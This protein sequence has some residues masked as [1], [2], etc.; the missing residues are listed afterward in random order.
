MG[1]L[2]IGATASSSGK[3][4]ITI[5]IL[6]KLMQLGFT[7][8]GAKVG[9]DFIDPMFHKFITGKDSI[10]LDAFISGESHVN[11][12]LVENSSGIDITIIEG[13]LGLYDG[14]SIDES[15][16]YDYRLRRSTRFLPF[17]STA[18]IAS[19]TKTPVILV[20]DTKS[21]VGSSVASVFGF[22]NI[23]KTLKIKG[24]ILNNVAN[25][26]HLRS[27][28]QAFYAL[29]IP[30][31][32]HVFRNKN[33]LLES[34]HLGLIPVDEFDDKALKR[35]EYITNTVSSTLDFNKIVEISKT[36][37]PL[38]ATPYCIKPVV[39]DINIGVAK[40]KSFNFYYGINL[41]R[42]EQLGAELHYFDPLRDESLPNNIQGIYIGGGFPEIFAK[43][44]ANNT[45]L[46][47][48]LKELAKKGIPIF[49]ECGGL[50]LLSKT[51]NDEPM[52]GVLPT[53][54]KITD[55]LTLGYI[56][57]NIVRNTCISPAGGIL[58]GH[59]Y[60]YTNSSPSGNVAVF[61][62]RNGIKKSGFQYKEVF[63]SYLHLHFG[64]DSTPV[65]HFLKKANRYKQLTT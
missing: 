46:L 65:S 55:K 19:I 38:V 37:P 60:H 22:L 52:A 10:N 31:V 16:S 11:R 28:N 51:L 18:H 63:G 3:T 45:P 62:S 12:L 34:R 5:A 24:I 8:S 26:S 40:G 13:V 42:F 27:L 6:A 64:S 2:I 59:E 4:T 58:K 33:L 54:V 14:A 39:K 50:L 25:E 20:V 53:N 35:L 49:A 57:A 23:N 41:K 21:T 15:L 9:P 61:N 7:V 29:N 47:V 56:S 48:N 43:E 17:G 36:A 32:G 44:I 30:I 1:R